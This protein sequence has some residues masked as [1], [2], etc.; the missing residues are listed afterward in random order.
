MQAIK[1][2]LRA[3]GGT[4]RSLQDDGLEVAIHGKVLGINITV[5]EAA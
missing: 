4:M 5:R 3:L 1:R 2:T